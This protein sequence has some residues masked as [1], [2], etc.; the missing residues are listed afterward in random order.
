MESWILERRVMPFRPPVPWTRV[1]RHAP[2]PLLA[3]QRLSV[4]KQEMAEAA[5]RRSVETRAALSTPLVEAIR[6][7]L[8]LAL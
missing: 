5:A 6:I 2:W 3:H 8:V 1:V 7:C 4:A